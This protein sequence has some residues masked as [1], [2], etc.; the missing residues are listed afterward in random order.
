[1]NP[2]EA[3]HALAMRVLQSDLYHKLDDL[4]RSGCDV[5]LRNEPQPITTDT[6]RLEWVMHHISGREARAMGIVNSAGGLHWWR[7]AI[8]HAMFAE[9]LQKEQSNG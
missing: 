8:D 7:D 5:L 6:D 2:T 3:M 9:A 4:E 1:M